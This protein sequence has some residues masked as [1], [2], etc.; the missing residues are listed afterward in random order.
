MKH[1]GSFDGAV[2]CGL[3]ALYEKFKPVSSCILD[4][5]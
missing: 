1:V 3:Q 4:W 2:L 5:T